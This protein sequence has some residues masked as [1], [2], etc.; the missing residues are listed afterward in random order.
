MK[1]QLDPSQFFR[2]LK[3][4]RQ[5]EEFWTGFWP[6]IRVGIRAPELGRRHILTPMRALL[7]GSSAGVMVAAAMLVLAFLVAPALKQ[8]PQRAGYTATALKASMPAPD[9]MA[10]P[11]VME[12]LGSASARV[13][14]F[15]VGEKADAT[16]VILI[17][18]EAIDL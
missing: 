4:A 8:M 6:S 16:D 1:P 12:E 5:P 3:Q 18:D 11:P 15:H 14:T 9:E 10:S 17:V 13:Y 7:V 2:P